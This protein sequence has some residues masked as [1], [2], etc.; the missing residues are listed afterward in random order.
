MTSQRSF[1]SQYFVDNLMVSLL[2]KVFSK[3]RN[4]HARRPHLHLVNFRVH[5]SRV[6]GQFIAQ[7]DISRVSQPAYRPDLA[8]SDF[9]LFGHL[10]NSLA[11]RMFDDLEELLDGITSFLE[12][13]QPSKLHVV[14]SHWT[15]RVSWVLENN[16]DYYH[17]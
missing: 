5:F 2:E 14:F 1:G 9:W 13:V 16:E 6:V 12:E 3:G 11:G 10:K 17:G 7:K 4:P 15:E 8:P